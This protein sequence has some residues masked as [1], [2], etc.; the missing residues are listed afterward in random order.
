MNQEQWYNLLEAIQLSQDSNEG[1]LALETPSSPPGYSVW[2]SPRQQDH[3]GSEFLHR[4]TPGVNTAWSTVVKFLLGTTL[5]PACCLWS[6]RIWK[7]LFMIHSTSFFSDVTYQEA[8]IF[9]N[10]RQTCLIICFLVNIARSPVKLI[11]IF[12]LLDKLYRLWSIN[13]IFHLNIFLS[14]LLSYSYVT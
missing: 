9:W 11:F 3:S 2:M 1:S 8:R 7:P 10:H 14:F 4:Q 5:Q 12:H 13:N 6:P